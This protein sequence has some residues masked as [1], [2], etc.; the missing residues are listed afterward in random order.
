[1]RRPVTILDLS[2]QRQLKTPETAK[3]RGPARAWSHSGGVKTRLV[4]GV[5]WRGPQTARS[6]EYA[7]L[8]WRS[9][10]D[11]MSDQSP[12]SRGRKT[13]TNKL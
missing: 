12:I 1:M 2:E 3:Q 6:P 13:G 9:P 8:P 7:S 4:P 10:Q 11:L 5:E